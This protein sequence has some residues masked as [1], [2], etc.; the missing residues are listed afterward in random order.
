MK[1]N[2]T[3]RDGE[4][5]RCKCYASKPTPD[6][7]GKRKHCC[8]IIYF[9]PSDKPPQASCSV[10]TCDDRQVKK[11]QGK[12]VLEEVKVPGRC[13]PDY[14]K[15][16][17]RDSG[18]IY[19]I[20]EGWRGGDLCRISNCTLRD[21]EAETEVSYEICESETDCQEG[22]Q[23]ETSP[24]TCCGA[25]VA[26]QCRMEDGTMMSPGQTVTD[27]S[28][29]NKPVRCEIV[30]G[31]PL[32]ERS[33]APCPALPADCPPAS[34]RLDSSGCCKV[35][36]TCRDQH[37]VT[38]NPGDSWKSDNCTS[39]TCQGDTLQVVPVTP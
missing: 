18:N 29:C 28:A 30:N 1:V 10:Q 6:C 22:Y 25:C 16:A 38:R 12:Y 14:K 8:E 13:C 5:R 34:Q 32:I 33:S 36:V 7:P 19:Q 20:G 15:V 37:N 26:K 31:T 21:G 17:C 2:E 3:W 9:D 4:C 23:Y 27:N 11:D 35:C 39:C 24:G